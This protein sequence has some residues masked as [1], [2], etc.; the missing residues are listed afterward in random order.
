MSDGNGDFTKRE[1]AARLICLYGFAYVGPFEHY[2]HKLMDNLFK[3]YEGNE[4][5][6]KKVILEQLVLHGTTSSDIMRTFTTKKSLV[7]S[8]PIFLL[9]CLFS[10][11][12]CRSKSLLC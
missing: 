5:V 4:A 8:E 9:R 3:G 2:L 12:Y 10:D 11:I 7:L 1:W 6:A